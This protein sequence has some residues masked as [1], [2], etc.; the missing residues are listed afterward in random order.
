MICAICDKEM[1][2]DAV[3][4]GPEFSHPRCLNIRSWYETVYSFCSYLLVKCCGTCR[5]WEQQTK[6][7][8]PPFGK[9]NWIPGALPAWSKFECNV[10]IFKSDGKYCD[11][12][13]SIRNLKNLPWNLPHK[14]REL[15]KNG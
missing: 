8:N 14:K 9:C 4:F 7:N 2:Q 13:K 15:T 3:R 1:Y 5:F 11:T 6:Y 12:Y 10:M